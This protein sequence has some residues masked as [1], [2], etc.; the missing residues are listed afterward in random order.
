MMSSKPFSIAVCDADLEHLHQKLKA[1][2]FP[3]ELDNAGWDMGVPL[4]EIKRL[5]AYWKDGFDWRKQEQGLNQQLKQYILPM[6]V[7]G[8]ENIDLHYIHHPSKS[9][10]STPLLFIH[11]WPGSFIEVTKLIPLLTSGD[12][13][14]P[15][16]DVVAPSLPNFGFSSGVKKRGFGLKQYAEALNNLMRALGYKQYVIQG[17]DWGS[18]I[19][20]TM[21]RQYSSQVKAIHLNFMPLKIPMPWQNPLFCAKNLLTIPFSPESKAYLYTTFSYLTKGSGYAIQQAT[22]PQTI[23]YALHDS[24]VALLSWI[25]DKLHLWTDNYPWTDD[26]I[27]TWVSI[28][29][30]S[31]AGPA[32][33]TRI[34]YETSEDGSMMESISHP[35]PRG[36]KVGMAQFK[37]ELMKYPPSW[38]QL[39][40][41]EVRV[42]EYPTG[43]HFAAWEAPE[44]LAGDLREFLGKG[45]L[46]FGV[47][48]G[49]NGIE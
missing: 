34:Y 38:A 33:S 27:L 40:G 21:A 36:V 31:A 43:G 48:K 39:L 18:F 10:D 32:A 2:T 1:T 35:A 49:R 45:G 25:Y 4:G 3:D 7:D 12:E 26:E 5:T 30:F 8:F 42:K 6:S 23:G 28:Y 29:L 16:F 15:V 9:A 41:Y 19:S 20:R 24:P 14:K 47:V 37:N 11:G 17:G 46:A 22:R 13:N 44:L